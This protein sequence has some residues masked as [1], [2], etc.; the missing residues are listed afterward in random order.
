MI[1]LH[2]HLQPQFKNELFHILH[3]RSSINSSI[4]HF[5]TRRKLDRVRFRKVFWDRY[6]GCA[7][8]LLANFFGCPHNSPS[9]RS[10]CVSWLLVSKVA[11]RSFYRCG[12]Y[13]E[14]IRCKECYW[15][16]RGAWAWSDRLAQYLRS[17]YGPIFLKVFL[18]K[19]CNGKKGRAVGVKMIAFFPR[20][21]QWSS[22]FAWKARVN[23]E[24]VLLGHPLILLKS[25]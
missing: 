16:P 8:Q 9:P 25:N 1:I 20:N 23:T 12:G 17:F 3:I 21:I 13:M 19:D 2:F 15:M 4:G 24:R 10:L 6:R 7:I 5:K 11:N 14:L 22:L 18:E